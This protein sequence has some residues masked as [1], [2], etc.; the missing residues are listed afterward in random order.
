MTLRVWRELMAG[1][2]GK[3]Q[4]DE[5]NAAEMCV[6]HLSLGAVQQNQHPLAKNGT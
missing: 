2:F 4:C 6:K 3:H 1:V 5:Y